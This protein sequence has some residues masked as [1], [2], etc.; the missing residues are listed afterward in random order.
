MA[1]S[2]SFPSPNAVWIRSTTLSQLE[3]SV[4]VFFLLSSEPSFPVLSGPDIVIPSVRFYCFF[5]S[6]SCYFFLATAS[7]PFMCSDH[8][9]EAPPEQ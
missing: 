3:A 7:H 1:S 8:T 2:T 5:A 6:S 4:G 9:P